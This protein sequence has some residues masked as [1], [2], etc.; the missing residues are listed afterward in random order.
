MSLVYPEPDMS[1]FVPVGLDGRAGEVIFEAVHRESGATIHWHLDED[2]V[3]S[4]RVFHQIAMSPEP[5]EH[6]I[7]LVDEEGRRL[8]RRFQVVSPSRRGGR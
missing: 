8:E 4:T 1:V 6:R 7:V 3:A 2:Y 5:G